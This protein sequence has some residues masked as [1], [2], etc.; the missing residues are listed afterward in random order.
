MNTLPV[1]HEKGPVEYSL[2]LSLVPNSCTER[3][4]ATQERLSISDEAGEASRSLGPPGVDGSTSSSFYE[5]SDGFL[6][7]CVKERH[8]RED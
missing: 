6:E 2:N 4:F 7:D 3:P 5:S 8:G 1:F